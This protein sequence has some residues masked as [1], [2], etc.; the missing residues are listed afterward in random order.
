MCQQIKDI[1]GA[2]N[3][4]DDII[5]YGKNQEAHDQVLYAVLR[6]FPQVDLTLKPEKCE[7]NKRSITFLG[8]CFHKKEFHQT[9]KRLKQFMMLPYQRQLRKSETF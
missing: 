5:I 3:I 9:L 4:S 2:L 1:P 8:L 7:L 6:K